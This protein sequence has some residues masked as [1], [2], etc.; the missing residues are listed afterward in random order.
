M[1]QLPHCKMETILSTTINN[2]IIKQEV[3]DYSPA[4]QAD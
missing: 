2:A 1:P 4:N 3:K